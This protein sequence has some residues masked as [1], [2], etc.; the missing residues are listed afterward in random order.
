MRKILT[1]ILLLSVSG[2]IFAQNNVSPAIT[3]AMSKGDA[4]A[5]S[6]FFNENVEMV[7]GTVNDVF[8][9]R[10]ASGILNDFFRRNQVASFQVIH[11][12]SKEHS[13]FI[14]ASMRAGNSNYRVY[15]LVRIVN[16]QQLIQQLRIEISNEE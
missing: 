9:K 14:I 11:R 8:S 5:V 16:N 7:V 2:W 3:N 6:S 12:G 1:L 10:Q 13:A 15:I 4:N